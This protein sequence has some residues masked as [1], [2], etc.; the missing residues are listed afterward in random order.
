[1]GVRSEISYEREGHEQR[2]EELSVLEMQLMD[3]MHKT[4]ARKNK[5][6]SELQQRSELLLN[7]V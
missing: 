6:I 7:A 2:I 4:I 3:R 1:M 5:V